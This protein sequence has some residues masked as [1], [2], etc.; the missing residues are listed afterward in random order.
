MFF[1][2]FFSIGNRETVTL[3]GASFSRKRSK[4]RC[5]ASQN[6][7][8]PN[9]GEADPGGAPPE[10]ILLARSYGTRFS[11]N[12]LVAKLYCLWFFYLRFFLVG[13]VGIADPEAGT[14]DADAKSVNND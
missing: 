14:N 1:P 7:G 10:I 2:Q 13:F 6:P 4:K 12:T 3:P 9:L 11:K 8:C 5:S